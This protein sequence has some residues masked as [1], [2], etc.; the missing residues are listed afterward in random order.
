MF[1]FIQMKYIRDTQPLRELE[2]LLL[3]ALLHLIIKRLS[4]ADENVRT[5]KFA[6][7]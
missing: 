6:H 2:D 1:R 3:D 4:C 7:K 5:C